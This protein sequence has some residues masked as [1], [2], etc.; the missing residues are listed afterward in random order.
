MLSVNI[1]ILLGYI[2]GSHIP[3]NITPFV[4]LILPLS[5]FIF[6]LCF[7]RESPVHLI[8]KGKLKAA[9]KSFRYYKN[10]QDTG[11][12]SGM[13]EF[14]EMKQKLTEDDKLVSNVTIKDFCK[15]QSWIF[16]VKQT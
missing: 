12:A 3:F 6:T 11:R 15:I 14:D 9:E 8:R 4:V 16:I 7:I 2:M 13:S 1:G 5:Y 10:I